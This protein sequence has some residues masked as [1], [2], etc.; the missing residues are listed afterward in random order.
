MS[1]GSGM[2][3]FNLVVLM[4]YFGCVIPQDQRQT[5]SIQMLQGQLEN[6][7]KLMINLTMTVSQLQREVH[8]AEDHDAFCPY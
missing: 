6:V 7:T 8:T 1:D 2:G 3:W 4:L 5:E